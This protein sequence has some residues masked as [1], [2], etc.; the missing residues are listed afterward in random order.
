MG[1]DCL[2]QII[3]KYYCFDYGFIEQIF[4]SPYPQPCVMTNIGPGMELLQRCRKISPSKDTF[5]HFPTVTHFLY[6]TVKRHLSVLSEDV[7]LV[8]Q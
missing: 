2:N 6:E 1:N 7:S 8:L 4:H 3:K 5:M